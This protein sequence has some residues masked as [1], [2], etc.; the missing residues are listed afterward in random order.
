MI[1]SDFASL[2]YSGMHSV[3]TFGPTFRAEKSHTRRHLSEFYMVEA[4]TVTMETGM[5]DLLGLI[6]QMYKSTVDTVLR[7][8]AD[9]VKLFHQQIAR[10]ETK[11]C[12]SISSV[13]YTWLPRLHMQTHTHTLTIHSCTYT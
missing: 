7:K 8:S 2:V 1:L 5:G 4:E 12:T 10:P 6:E 13:P 9:D 3:Y 11:V